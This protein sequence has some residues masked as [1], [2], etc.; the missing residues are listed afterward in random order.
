MSTLR[1]LIVDDEPAARQVL[2]EELG[3][4]DDVTVAGEAASGE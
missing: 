4:F 3:G 1:T 2:R